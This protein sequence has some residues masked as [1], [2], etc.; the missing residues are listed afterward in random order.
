MAY[1]GTYDERYYGT[2]FSSFAGDRDAPSYLNSAYVLAEGSVGY[3][4]L[5][6]Q[7]YTSD[8]DVYS[9]GAL[10]AGYYSVDVD[11]NI[12]DYSTIGIGGVSKFQVINSSGTIVANSFTIYS[13]IE[14]TVSSSDTYYVKIVGNTFGDQQYSVNYSFYGEI[15]A[16]NSTAVWAA[17]GS[18][19][20]SLI[21]GQTIDASVT[22]S[23]LDGNSDGI[24]ATYWYLDGFYQ[25]QSE[26]F[27]LADDHISQSLSFNFA[28]YDD[29]GNFE[30]S[31]FYIAGNISDNV[32]DVPTG[33]VTISGTATEGETLTVDTSSIADADGLGAITY[34]WN[35]DG[36][37]IS[38]ATANT[39]T[40]TQ[41]DVGTQLTGT[42]SYTDGEGALESLTS[43]ATS[44]VVNVND[45]P[46]G[47]VTI[48]G[49]A[50]EGET[51]TVDTSSIADADGLG[52][53]TYQWNRDGFAISGATANTYTLTQADVG[54]QITGTASYTDGEGALES[55][56]SSVM[57]SV[58]G[59]ILGTSANETTVG[60]SGSDVI[61]GRSGDDVIRGGDGDDK[62]YGNSDNDTLEGGIG[63][64]Y[65]S[66]GNHT[67]SVT[68]KNDPGSVTVDLSLGQASDGYGGMDTLNSIEQVY[69]SH[70]ADAITGSENDDLLAGEGGDD[71]LVGNEG[72]D[73]L[74]GGSGSD[75][76]SGGLGNDNLNGGSGLDTADYTGSS[77][78]ILAR[79][80]KGTVSDGDG[81]TDTLVDIENITGSGFND[82]LIGDTGANVL[83]GGDGNDRLNGGGGADRLVGGNGNDI[84]TVDSA[85]DVVVELAGGGLDR[86]NAF[87]NCTL[88][89][90]VEY[91][92]GKF[93]VNWALELK[94]SSGNDRMSGTNKVSFADTLWGNDGRDL[95]HGMVGNDT[96]YG[97]AGNDRIFG[98]SGDDTIIGGTGRDRMTGQFG[99][100]TFVFDFGDGRDR[101]TDFDDRGD[102]LLDLTALSTDFAAVENQMMQQGLHVLIDFRNGDTI[103]LERT[104][105]AS[106]T[107]DDFLF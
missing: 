59:Y 31:P 105:L 19:T 72:D 57:G 32:N 13:D 65:L 82:V 102:D 55:V 90:N 36:S 29:A 78:A 81:G 39:Y 62:L 24:V 88:P 76:L 84:Y 33:A 12:W 93:C 3:G 16:D 17:A 20:G 68:Y 15:V 5:T 99:D 74:S 22:Y 14:F 48:S 37:A 95:I 27:T 50:T 80:N 44:A 67:D 89:E 53:I 64:D 87:W 69:G 47:T 106:I 38:G 63:N 97:G 52:A 28:F 60:S 77:G 66:G 25:R 34:Q 101:I 75:G 79:L 85:D 43:A 107:S 10:S 18:Y 98:Q 8:T 1:T 100:D 61:L 35:R 4:N 83:T 40:L 54:T 58:G 92:V 70:F 9:L 94:G 96:L 23:D 6:H 45:V 56:T 46:T 7:S 86:I 30:I 91:L 26:T 71:T 11:Y 49:T 41:A 2:G 42:A 104:D 103:L 73:I 51:L 21:S